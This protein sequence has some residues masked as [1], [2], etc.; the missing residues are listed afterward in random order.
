[1]SM[2]HSL[3]VRPLLLDH[4][5]VEFVFAVKDDFKILNGQSKSLLIVFVAYHHNANVNPR[6]YNEFISRFCVLAV[7]M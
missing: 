6:G 5:L 2:A 1:M 7:C 3:E 4:E